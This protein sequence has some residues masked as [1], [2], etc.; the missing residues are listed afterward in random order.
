MK[1]A[2][3]EQQGISSHNALNDGGNNKKPRISQTNYGDV[4]AQYGIMSQYGSSNPFANG[5]NSPYATY[6]QPNSSM[7]GV[8]YANPQSMMASQYGAGYPQSFVNPVAAAAAAAAAATGYPSANTMISADTSRTIYLG[9]FSANMEPYELLK[10]VHTGP[11]ESFRIV[12][13]KNCA[14][15]SFV[16]PAAAQVFYQEHMARKLIVNNVEIKIGWGKASNLSASLR[17]QIQRGATRNVYLGRL[18]E[19]DTE[20]RI[21]TALSQFGP[22]EQ[23]RVIPEKSIAFVHFL[24]IHSATKCVSQLP[25]DPEWKEKRISYGRDHCA[26]HADQYGTAALSF[27]TPYTAAAAVAATGGGGFGFDPY[28][29]AMQPTMNPTGTRQRTLYFGNIHYDATCEDICNSIRGGNLL[30]I[31]YLI[32]RHIAF[33]TF[34]DPNAAMTVFNLASTTGISIRGKRLR[35]GWGKPSAI[36]N[37]IA[38]AIQNGA[39]RN[40]YIGGIGEDM[41]V[42]KLRKDFAEYGEIEMVNIYKEKSC[43]FVNFTSIQS[44]IHALNSIS[45]SKPEYADLKINFGKD[46]CGTPTKSS[47]KSREIRDSQLQQE[48]LREK[49]SG[50]QANTNGNSN[51]AAAATTTTNNNN[52]NNNAKQDNKA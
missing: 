46:R 13:D 35:V 27:Q 41:T 26:D 19:K 20:D 37:Q 2:A 8:G 52:N 28:G 30:Q 51:S 50:Q 21:R 39:T 43:A 5:A 31:R 1:R 3:T 42:E 10:Q 4:Y 14:F 48:Y 9:N 49:Q 34:T 22:I 6:G 40:I 25:D 45:N 36:P 38:V 29:Y 24:S 33:V 11:I 23:V 47:L 16:E 18:D 7:Y 44:A 17:A 15:L 32:D 12:P